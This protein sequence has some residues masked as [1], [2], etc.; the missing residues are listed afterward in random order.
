MALGLADMM[1]CTAE[2]RVPLADNERSRCFCW[3]CAIAT[4]ES[5]GAGAGEHSKAITAWEPEGQSLSAF[6]LLGLLLVPDQLGRAWWSVWLAG[7]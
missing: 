4:Q 5:E 3:G 1:G 2:E 6:D 7:L